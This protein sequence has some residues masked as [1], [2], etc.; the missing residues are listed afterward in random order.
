MRLAI[1]ILAMLFILS[2]AEVAAQ[3]LP[4]S[5]ESSQDRKIVYKQRTEIDF[6][7]IE[8]EGQLVKP[9]G[10]LILDRRVGTFN[11]LIR[12]RTDFDEEIKSSVNNIK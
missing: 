11:P 7:G 5:D 1:E 10:S 6:E 8:I 2:F 3:D 9:Q 4:E 12:L